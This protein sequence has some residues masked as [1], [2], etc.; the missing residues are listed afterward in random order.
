MGLLNSIFG[1]KSAGSL[2]TFDISF[3]SIYCH[4]GKGGHYSDSLLISSYILFLSRYFFICDDRQLIPM[5]K[6]LSKRLNDNYNFDELINDAGK[7]IYDTLNESEKE[8]ISQLSNQKIIL[9]I[10]ISNKQAGK[11]LGNYRFNIVKSS[12]GLGSI[13]DMSPGLDIELLPRL[14]ILFYEYILSNLSDRKSILILNKASGLFLNRNKE[15]Q[16][17]REQETFIQLP[18][19]II[20]EIVKYY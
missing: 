20:G 7:L 10:E 1:K 11:S 15:D 3:D 16:K 4:I 6:L 5:R 9:P 18:Q 8:Q 12:V 17:Y 19:E 2:A 14:A 13:F